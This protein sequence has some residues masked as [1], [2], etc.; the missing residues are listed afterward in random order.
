M[1]RIV[2]LPLVL[3]VVSVVIA[4]GLSSFQ[5]VKTS[6]LVNQPS[7]WVGMGDLHL[8]E[9]MNTPFAP[10]PVMVGIGN[11]HRYEALSSIGFGDLRRVE[12][13]QLLSNVG[14]GDL[15]RFEAN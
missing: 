10:V 7:R 13:E 14:M 1:K 15:H 9:S 2:V 12:S 3:V 4:I 11:L 5:A 8:V 6:G